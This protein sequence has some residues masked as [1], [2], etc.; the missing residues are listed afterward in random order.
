M[1]I[2]CCDKSLIQKLFLMILLV[3][4]YGCKSGTKDTTA[5]SASLASTISEI[6]CPYGSGIDGSTGKY[7]SCQCPSSHPYYNTSSG[8]CT[9]AKPANVRCFEDV[10]RKVQSGRDLIQSLD[11]NVQTSGN[12]L[13]NISGSGI[14]FKGLEK[15]TF[16]V[17][18]QNKNQLTWAG[19]GPG[20]Y[21]IRGD[22]QIKFSN[23]TIYAVTTISLSPDGG[24]VMIKAPAVSDSFFAHGCELNPNLLQN[25]EK[26]APGRLQ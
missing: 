21:I 1:R 11:L 26:M 3:G 17:S 19:F 20:S 5:D 24:N 7:I 22:G 18:L 8:M 2:I 14:L 15:Q 4:I 16:E 10:T 23:G 6:P 9:N 12:Q 13:T 25:F